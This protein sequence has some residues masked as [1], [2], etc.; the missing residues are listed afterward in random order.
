MNGTQCLKLLWVATNDQQ[1]I[2]PPDAELQHVFDQG[3]MVG[4]LAQQLYPGGIGL[5]AEGVDTNLEETQASLA[6]LKP[7]F[8]AGFTAA[9]LYCRV[10]ILNPVGEDRWD[11]IEVKST[12]EVKD[13]HLPDIAF[14]RHCCTLAGLKVRRC[15]IMHLNREYVRRGEIDPIQ[16]FVTEDVTD[17][18]REVT[19][20]LEAKIQEML[21]VIDAEKCPE[22]SI[23]R[24][25]NAPYDCQLRQQCWEH[26]PEHHVMTLYY[27]KKL[28]E[29][30]IDN[31]ILHICDIPGDVSLNSKQLTQ[32]TCVECGQPH[33][34]T[35]EIKSFLKRLKY[36]LY[37][38]DF[39]TF[40]AAVPVYDGTR[41]YQNV[42]F[43]FS[44]HM[45]RKPGLE[46]E[47]HSYLGDGSIDP[48]PAFLAELK[49]TIG[50]V[51]SVVVYYEVFEKTRL[52]EL[53]VDFPDYGEWIN[54]ILERIVD[55]IKP[56]KDFS[57]YHPKQM[58]SASL[59]QVLPALTDLSYDEL[60]IMDGTTASIKFMD[61]AFGDTPDEDKEKIFADLLVYCKQDTCGMIEI[62]RKLEQAVDS[63]A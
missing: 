20:G 25:C 47:H 33:V 23:G 52:K 4:E 21:S 49:K 59:K 45:V 36:P 28:G 29:E 1:R 50:P 57:Y 44:V 34:N 11:I 51:G 30:L 32:K 31:G 26:L 39:E 62:I 18:L 56:F 38:V 58:G 43:Q 6:L 48:R 53:A 8:E 46:P 27:G 63:K 40:A 3:H 14:Q 5:S 22:V 16:L 2:P 55:L 61:A 24:H 54:G 15:H 19:S 60:E 17:R 41:P 37:C 12:N 35:G 42:P 10:D 13:E 9:R 7:L